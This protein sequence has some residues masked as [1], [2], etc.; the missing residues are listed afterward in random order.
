MPGF[1]TLCDVVSQRRAWKASAAIRAAH[2]DFTPGSKNVVSA[3][4]ENLV[5]TAGNGSEFRF[6]L[7]GSVSTDDGPKALHVVRSG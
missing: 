5:A 3:S 1:K 7:F 6:Y 4:L 2:L